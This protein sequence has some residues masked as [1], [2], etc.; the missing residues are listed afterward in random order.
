MCHPAD[1]L[2]RFGTRLAAGLLPL[3]LAGCALPNQPGALVRPPTQHR[4]SPPA[5]GG[6]V[7]PHDLP[8]DE[9]MHS[10]AL[11]DGALGWRQ[12]CPP[13]Q[14]AVTQEAMR[15]EADGQR[16]AEAGHVHRI[17]VD[18]VGSRPMPPEGQIRFYM[19]VAEMAD[20]SAASRVYILRTQRAGCVA[21]V[22]V[23]DVQQ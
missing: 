14:K 20:G 8:A 15:S 4:T 16:A 7:N 9:F 11:R 23:E 22:V 21:D 6:R 18:F 12:L 10:V 13:L 1:W 19:L 5:G 2:P 17:R 3:V